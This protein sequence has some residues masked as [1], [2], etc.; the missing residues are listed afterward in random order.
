M[1]N[2]QT[3]VNH[4]AEYFYPNEDI[5]LTNETFTFI[6]EEVKKALPHLKF[7]DTEPFTI[8]SYYYEDL[9]I[10]YIDKYV[11]EHMFVIKFKD[12]LHLMK[13]KED[14]ERNYFN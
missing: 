9:E 3:I 2:I 4:I 13:I 14:Y 1:A 6:Y 12:K 5:K 10:H 11:D 7:K 8:D